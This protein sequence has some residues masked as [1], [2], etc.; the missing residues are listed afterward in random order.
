[1]QATGAFRMRII[2][3][4]VSMGAGTRAKGSREAHA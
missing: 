1:M 3:V 4:F 2:H